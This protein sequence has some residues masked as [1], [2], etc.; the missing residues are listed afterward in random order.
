MSEEI[1]RYALGYAF[2]PDYRHV[3]AM[4]KGGTSPHAGK[5]LAP[6][7]AV[8]DADEDDFVAVSREFGEEVELAAT[9]PDD[10]FYITE[11]PGAHGKPTSYFWTVVENIHQAGPKTKEP[12][13]ILSVEDVL[14]GSDATED[15]RE[16]VLQV[17]CSRRPS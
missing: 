9:T 12:V 16:M 8:D 13:Y 6:G 5:F 10:W 14:S 11:K 17:V 3:I 7:G 1:K 4:V 2:S 15:F